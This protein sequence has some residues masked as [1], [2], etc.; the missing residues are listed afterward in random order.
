MSVKP[1]QK[2]IFALIVVLLL[3][4]SFL[5][6]RMYNKPMNVLAQEITDDENRAT[7]GF[8]CNINEVAMYANRAHI[9]CANSVAVGSDTVWFFAIENTSANKTFINRVIAIGLTNM[10]MNRWVYVNYDTSS[11]NNPPGCLTGDC[12]KLVAILGWK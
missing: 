11:S 9:R 7:A 10:S 3:L 1:V 5:A 2:I 6:G 4:A 12:R 8:N